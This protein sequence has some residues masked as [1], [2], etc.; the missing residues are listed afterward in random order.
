MHAT[1]ETH[2]YFSFTT[3][4][5]SINHSPCFD[6]DYDPLNEPNDTSFILPLDV[7]LSPPPSSSL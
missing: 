7:S 5:D 2:H 1:S 3:I 4:T 6:H